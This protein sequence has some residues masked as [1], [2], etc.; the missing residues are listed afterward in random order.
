MKASEFLQLVH[1]QMPAESFL[2]ELGM[3]DEDVVN[4]QRSF[5]FRERD[6]KAPEGVSELER[7]I[8]EYD[9]S[10]LEVGP[11]R[12]GDRILVTPQGVC[13]GACEADP[14][15]VLPDGRIALFDHGRRDVIPEFCAIDSERFLDGLATS[16]NIGL[17]R[18]AWTGRFPEAVLRC[19]EAAGGAQFASFF[20]MVCPTLE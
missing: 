4:I 9:C 7:M 1:S 15:V 12:F 13:V 11:V 14:L 19:S 2:R 17:D 8:I 20:R 5:I 3:N 18:K 6:V 10:T 16:I